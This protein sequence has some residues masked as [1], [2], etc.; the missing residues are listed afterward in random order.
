MEIEEGRDSDD[1]GL[2]SPQCNIGLP[3]LHVMVKRCTKQIFWKFNR[4]Y[5]KDHILVSRA[6]VTPRVWKS[7]SQM[8]M[9][10]CLRLHMLK[11]KN[12][13]SVS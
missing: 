1:T 10:L 8:R 5:H 12:L 3:T 9:S 4:S 7:S 6:A 2:S 13:T 11:C